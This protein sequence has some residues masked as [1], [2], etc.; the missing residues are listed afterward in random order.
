MAAATLSAAVAAPPEVAVSPELAQ[1]RV[2]SRLLELARAIRRPRS[3]IGYSC[4][5]CFALHR[6]CRPF[7][8]E[9][10]NRVDI[11][12]AFAPWA[13]DNC[14][15]EC[16]V[17]GVCCCLDRGGGEDHAE[18][19]PVSATHPLAMCS[20]FVAGAP[21]ACG[22]PA[23]HPDSL[24]G[25]YS[26]VLLDFFSHRLSRV[27]KLSLDIVS[28]VSC[29]PDI[30]G[31]RIVRFVCSIIVRYRIARFARAGLSAFIIEI[32]HFAMLRPVKILPSLRKSCY[33]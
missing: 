27:N 16:I 5:I 22:L 30:V 21:M 24:V 3:Y 8:W 20:H 1:A 2:A 23:P 19:K 7:I 29:A 6:K 13:L 15:L 12:D 18:M 10:A 33:P 4:F 17:D 31:Y 11:V 14:T 26:M 25:F 9:G 32:I 28:F